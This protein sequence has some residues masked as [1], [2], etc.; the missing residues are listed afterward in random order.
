MEHRWK[1]WMEKEIKRMKSLQRLYEEVSARDPEQTATT[2][3][4][5]QCQQNVVLVEPPSRARILKLLLRQA[6]SQAVRQGCLK[7]EKCSSLRMV[8]IMTLLSVISDRV[9]QFAFN[10]LNSV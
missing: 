10:Q 8:M 5:H 3:W 1:V 9:A 6:L 4:S 2:T 7:R